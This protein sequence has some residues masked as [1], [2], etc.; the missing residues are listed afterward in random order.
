MSHYWAAQWRSKNKL[1]G[2]REDWCYWPY[3]E[4]VGP[5]LFRTR[6]ECRNWITQH[7][8]YIR[9]RSDLKREPHGWLGV[10]PIKVTL[11]VTPIS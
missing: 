8:G 4:G 2:Y 7:Y 6:Q 10:R 9:R 11:S 3:W 1:D 5:R